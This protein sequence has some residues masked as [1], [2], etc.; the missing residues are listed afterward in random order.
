MIIHDCAQGENEWLQHRVGKVTASEF[1]NILTPH[2]K[3]KEGGAVNTYMYAKL[4]EAYRGKALPGFSSHA[5][6]QGQELEDEARNWYSLESDDDVHNVGFIEHDDRRCGC[7]PDALIGED[8][9]LEL[10][11]PEPTNHVR[12][13]IEGVLP[14]DYRTQVHGSLYVTGRKWWKFVSYRRSF[15]PFVLTVRRDEAICAKIQEAL[16]GFYK[17]YDDAMAKLKE[18]AA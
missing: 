11:C 8:G 1:K 9:G 16:T 7:S 13:L 5:T 6:E 17:A 4:A 15:P 14:E 12:Y 18:R 3:A 2:F 10:K